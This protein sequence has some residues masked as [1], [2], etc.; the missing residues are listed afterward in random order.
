MVA[1]VEIKDS[2][3]T[4]CSAR[5]TK[6]GQ[7]VTAPLGFSVMYP[8]KLDTINTA[9]NYIG[10][11]SKKIFVI[12]DIIIYANK[13]VGPNDAAVDIYEADSDTST[14]IL[15]SIFQTEIPKF[16][17]FIMTGLNL[18]TNEGVWLNGKTDDNSIFTNIGGYYIDA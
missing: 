10:P 9:F 4:G 18:I 16:S 11:I 13:D 15:R 6:R 8:K 5:V 7:L 14:T 12:T 17:N 3:G 2:R 1:N